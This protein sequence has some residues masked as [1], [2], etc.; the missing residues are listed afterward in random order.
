MLHQLDLSSGFIGG[1][2]RCE[3]LGATAIS[4]NDTAWALF[5]ASY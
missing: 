1:A 5:C 3:D 2:R 4:E